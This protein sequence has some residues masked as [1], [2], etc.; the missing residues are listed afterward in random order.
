[1]KRLAPLLLTSVIL[2]PTKV[3]ASPG[4][5]GDE[6][7]IPYTEF[8][9]ANGLR[10]IV[11]EDHSTPVAAVNV[12][13]HVGSGYEAPGR[14]GL[15][16]LFEHLMFEGSAHVPEGDF[17]N[18]LETAGGVNNGSTT[19]DRTNYYEIVPPGA[20]GLALWLEADRMGGLLASVDQKKLDLQRK[21][22]KNERRQSYENR[23]YGQFELAAAAAL[24]P[25]EHPYHHPTIGSMDDLDAAS[26]D[27]VRA[28]FRRY[29]N[30]QNA[31][32][33]VAGDVHTAEIKK[34]ATR[35]FG[36]IPAGPK[37]AR[38]EAKPPAIAKTRYI[39]LEDQVTLPRVYLM[40]RTVKRYA[41]DDAAID[42]LAEILTRGKN[43]RLY[44]R[45]VYGAQIA[46]S[47]VAYN[48]SQLLSGDLYLWITGKKGVKLDR[49][50]AAVMHEI[51]NL[52]AHPPTK[53]ELARAKNGIETDLLSSLER[54]A[55]KADKLNEYLYFA[56]D[57]GY[58]AKDLA[59]YRAVTAADVQRVAKAYLADRPRIVLSIVPEK[60][61]R[62]AATR[63]G[64]R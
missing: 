22:V 30:P 29:Y 55:R 54:V 49:L 57:P 26:L 5:A 8:H 16:H 11:A 48:D 43:S 9:L 10:V 38:P 14:T 59:R 56:G 45:L 20:V 19:N 40:W 2:C 15:A 7:A 24:Y 58:V 61:R 23:P 17:D 12:W 33:V 64:K 39:T 41:A 51:E 27:D 50:E 62:L 13:Y 3:T 36:W 31:V 18:W 63:K 35:Y 44:E 46:Q 32:V 25:P 53:D 6:V 47:V 60:A 28:F 52:A 21:V 1:M 4:D 34:L 42:V 37:V